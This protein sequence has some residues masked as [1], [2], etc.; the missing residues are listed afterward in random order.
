MA[1]SLQWGLPL[2]MHALTLTLNPHL[3]K[4]LRRQRGDGGWL[5]IAGSNLGHVALCSTDFWVSRARR[6]GLTGQAPLLTSSSAVPHS[7]DALLT[8]LECHAMVIFVQPVGG[9]WKGL[10]TGPPIRA[11]TRLLCSSH[12]VRTS[13]LGSECLLGQLVFFL[14][15]N[16]PSLSGKGF[17]GCVWYRYG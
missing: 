16:N 9:R 6:D 7:S 5:Q 15:V 11:P 10:V 3:T 2:G 12:L 4:D 1:S 8:C 17:I 14:D 13:C